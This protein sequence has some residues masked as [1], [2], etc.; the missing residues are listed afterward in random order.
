MTDFKL[1]AV[2]KAAEGINWDDL[3]VKAWHVGLVLAAAYASSHPGWEWLLP[4]LVP[5]AGMS[6]PPVGRG[7]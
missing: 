7:R 1:P 6:A 5:A 4:V 3:R 2:A